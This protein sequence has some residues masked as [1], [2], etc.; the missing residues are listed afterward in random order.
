MSMPRENVYFNA[1]NLIYQVGSVRMRKLLNYF[2][3]LETAWR[4]N[5]SEIRASGIEEPVA[6]K[7]LES[8]AKIDPEAEFAR[9]SDLS[10]QIITFHDPEYPKILKEIPNPPMVLYVLGQLLPQDETALAIVG[11]RKFSPYG[12]QVTEDIARDLVRAGLT[13]VSG[14]A[15]G[16]DAL[17]HKAAVFYGGRTIAVLASSVD[18]IYPASNRMTAEKILEGRGAIISEMPLGTPPLKHFFPHRNR[19]ISGLSL[20]TIVIEAASDSGSLI[21]AHHALEQNR[22]VYAIP[23]SIYNPVSIGPNNLLKM[24]AK[25]VTRVSDILEDLNLNSIQQELISSEVIGDNPEEEKILKLLTRQPQ[26]FDELAKKITLPSSTIAA[27][28]MILEMKG[29]IKNLGANQYVLAR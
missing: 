9:L 3:D 1:F 23:G 19:I 15:L 22:Q 28:L 14:L 26:H 27:T 4:A 24:G 7:I 10:I 17:A 25:P 12:K 20:G 5:L 29:K 11:T 13:V 21:T 6:M 16:I 18:N 2:P 8:R